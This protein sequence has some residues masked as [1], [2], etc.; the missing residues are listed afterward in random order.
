[1]KAIVVFEWPERFL[2]DFESDTA[3]DTDLG[4]LD[5]LHGRARVRPHTGKK[6]DSLLLLCG[7]YFVSLFHR[8]IVPW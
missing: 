3:S 1:V 7:N 2:F 5:E 4:I 8:G 6:D